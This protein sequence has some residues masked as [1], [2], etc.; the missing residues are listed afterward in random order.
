MR[1]LTLEAAL[2]NRCV[3]LVTRDPVLYAELAAE[4]R[5][6]RLP[7]ISLLPGDRIPEKVAV[8]LTTPAEVP[9]VSHARVV[10]V[11]EE[12]ERTGT[13]AEVGIALD[14]L[15]ADELIVGV[16]PG[17]RPGYALVAGTKP[18][19]AGVLESPE[20]VGRLGSHLRRRFPARAL[21]FRVGSGDRLSRD[22]ILNALLPVHR[23]VEL[24][25]E[26]GT[27]PR[28]RRRPRD[29][30]AARSIAQSIGRPVLD[31]PSLTTTP[32][33]VSNLQR[34]SREGSGGRFTIP[35]AT[36]ER[37]LRG[38]LTLVDAIAEG[39]RRYTA[40]PTLRPRQTRAAREPS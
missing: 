5:E 39:S 27:T 32:G 1:Y 11:P 28:G 36:A 14:A 10:P 2:R 9:L 16:D 38:E 19:A 15:D 25:D 26:Q 31:R 33:E 21:R 20:A 30:E 18:I 6:R 22:R 24:V 8:V 4:L 37:V 29:P 17:P 35:R 13:W 34:L 40:Q 23:P 12:G 7:S 3:A